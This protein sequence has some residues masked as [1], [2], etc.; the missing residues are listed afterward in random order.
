[1]RKKEVFYE[2]ICRFLVLILLINCAG[3]N[4]LA[5]GRTDISAEGLTVIP[6]LGFDLSPVSLDAKEEIN[7]IADEMTTLA[8]VCDEISNM[9]ISE[10]EKEA[11]KEL[12]ST[13]YHILKEKLLK[14]G[15]QKFTDEQKQMYVLGLNQEQLALQTSDAATIQNNDGSSTLATVPGVNYPEIPG[16]D[17]YVYEYTFRPGGTNELYQMAQCIALPVENVSSKMVVNYDTVNMYDTIKISTLVNK[18]IQL[19]A[20]EVSGYALTAVVGGGWSFVISALWDL[21]GDVLPSTSSSNEASLDLK[22]T[23]SSRVIHYWQK[24]DGT[25]TF[26]LATCAAIIRESWIFVDVNGEHYYKYHEFWAYSQYHRNSGDSRAVMATSPESYS[27]NIPYKT[28][29]TILGITYWQTMLEVSP[30]HAAVPL[31]FLN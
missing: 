3:F 19:S 22:V 9:P 10:K 14:L 26:K 17:F 16:I 24:I 13:K 6:D 12:P 7:R 18:L 21:A 25:Y 23:S 5:E 28:Q 30:F 27:I 29:N 11:L 2:K 1:M 4:V 31:E 8:L 15:A 20:E